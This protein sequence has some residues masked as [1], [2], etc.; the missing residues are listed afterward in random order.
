[1]HHPGV[2]VIV[3]APIIETGWDPALPEAK[4]AKIPVILA[5]PTIQTA[6]DSL[7]ACFI[8]ADFYEEGR[9]A[10]DWLAKFFGGK[11]APVARQ[12]SPGSASANERRK[13]SVDAVAKYPGLKIIHPPNGD[14][15]RAGGKEGKGGLHHEARPGDQRRLRP[16]RRAG[17]RCDPSY[18]SVRP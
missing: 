7:C 8:G 14:F 3:I 2:V 18:R 9:R 5:D 4:R 13:A 15:R 1:M 10:A 16:Q 11:G 12:G 17:P 6:D